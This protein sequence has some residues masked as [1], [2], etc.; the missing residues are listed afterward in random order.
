MSHNAPSGEPLENPLDRR[1]HGS[2][3]RLPLPA[4]KAA[5]IE[6]QHGKKSPA[7]RGEI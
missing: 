1:L 2:A 6:L 4:E 3:S 7:H 5:A